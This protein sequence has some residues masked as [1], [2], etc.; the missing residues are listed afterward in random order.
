M[1]GV[2]TFLTKVSN[3][4]DWEI[5][6]GGLREIAE[7]GAAEV[8]APTRMPQPACLRKNLGKD[9]KTQDAIR[10]LC[11]EPLP[12][13]D[14][15]AA[16][17][18]DMAAAAGFGCMSLWVNSPTPQFEAPCRVEPRAAPALS[19][20]LKDAGIE[21][22]NL[23][24]FRVGP[25]T[26]IS[27]YAAPLEL[28]AELGAK[29]ATAIARDGSS[30]TA[31]SLARLSQLA[32]GLGIR[33]NVEFLSYRG[34]DSLSQ[35]VE[36]VTRAGDAGTG[37]LLDILHLVRSGGSVD[38]VRTLDPQLVGH[39]QL[40]DGPLAAPSQGL[41]HESACDRMLPGTGEF[42]VAAFIAAL[43]P[44]TLGL[45]IPRTS[46][47]FRGLTPSERVSTLL[48]TTRSFLRRD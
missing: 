21:V 39:V 30:E 36:L 18:V 11:L 6:R 20:R 45:E 32:A 14:V 41:E 34:P 22:R 31:E 17:A 12:V 35:A 1:T 7:S 40:C 2:W 26:D 28:G 44:V 43:P 4:S 27:L 42:P 46:G 38:E 16:D 48:E 13:L 33:V 9:V 8:A 25:G 47:A 19:R 15:P 29:T 5:D 3:L 23:E 10:Q 37:I 24:V